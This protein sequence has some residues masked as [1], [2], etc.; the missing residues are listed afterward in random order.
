MLI[1]NK[2]AIDREHDDDAHERAAKKR[3]D[4]RNRVRQHIHDTGH[5]AERAQ[6]IKNAREKSDV[7][8]K[9]DF[10]IS[11]KAPSQRDATAG[12]RETR[13]EQNH[14]DRTTNKRQ[15]RGGTEPSR[16]NGRDHENSRTDCSANN[17][18]GER[19]DSDTANELVIDALGLLDL[20]PFPRQAWADGAEFPE[21]RQAGTGHGLKPQMWGFR[22]IPS[23]QIGVIF[24][25]QAS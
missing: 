1:D 11:V 18:R 16:D 25:C 13:H 6:K 10:D 8:A 24:A 23:P 22:V 14:C 15:R 20:H 21:I 7:T 19:W 3:N 17:I 12:N 4:E 9:R 5:R 2:K